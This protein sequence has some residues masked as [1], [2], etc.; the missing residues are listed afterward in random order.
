[1]N[2]PLIFLRPTCIFNRTRMDN[3]FSGEPNKL[4]STADT[5]TYIIC[6]G[7][8]I[9]GVITYQHNSDDQDP[10]LCKDQCFDK[11]D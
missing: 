8:K 11:L 5:K 4:Y 10:N 2:F 9:T 6:F 3:I 7:E 1:M